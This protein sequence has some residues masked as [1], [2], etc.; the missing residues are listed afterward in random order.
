[1]TVR[2]LVK[3]F[4]RDRIAG[5]GYFRGSMVIDHVG[6]HLGCVSADTVLRSLRDLRRRGEV[7]YHVEDVHKSLYFV[8]RVSDYVR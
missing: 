2:A 5:S 3:Q 4:C 8:W 6:A 1:M 7:D